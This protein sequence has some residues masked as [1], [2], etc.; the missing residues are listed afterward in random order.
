MIVERNDRSMLGAFDSPSE[1]NI[2]SKETSGGF[3][4][5]GAV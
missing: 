2:R 5:N 3:D 4:A 1:I